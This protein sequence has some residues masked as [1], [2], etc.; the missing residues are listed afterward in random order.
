MASRKNIDILKEVKAESYKLDW[1]RMEYAHVNKIKCDAFGANGRSSPCSNNCHV[2]VLMTCR[3]IEKELK[4]ICDIFSHYRT[5][6]KKRCDVCRVEVPVLWHVCS[7]KNAKIVVRGHAAEL[8][9]VRKNLLFISDDFKKIEAFERSQNKI[10][11]IDIKS[12]KRKMFNYGK[13]ES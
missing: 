11:N 4:R 10:E 5:Y 3:N 2:D 1:L 8:T 9:P 13:K 7:K 6:E 12:R